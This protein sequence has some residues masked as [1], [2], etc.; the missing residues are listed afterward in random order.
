VPAD[1]RTVR[2]RVKV[3]ASR[4]TAAAGGDIAAHIQ[5]AFAKVPAGTV[6]TIAE[7][8][9]AETAEYPTGAP[10]GGAITDRLFPKGE[11][12]VCTVEGIVPCLKDGKKAAKAAKK[13]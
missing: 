11:G 4:R 7:I 6:L 12:K 1:V 3:P 5:Q 2:G 13:A 10:S 9:N 8:K